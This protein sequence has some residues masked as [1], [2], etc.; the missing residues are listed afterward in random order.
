MARPRKE[1]DQEQFEKLC[2][3]QC[4]LKEI[5]GW[6]DCSE[7]TIENWCKRTYTDE[8]GEPIGFSEVYKKHSV[9]GKISLRRFQF[10]LAE[11]NTSMAIWLGKQWLGQRDQVDV[12]VDVNDRNGEVEALE[13]YF[14]HRKQ[15]GIS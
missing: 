15:E 2:A 3:I 11:K 14:K 13:E 8:D 10:K 1:I 6:F 12:G 5:A 7:D 9:A 4:T